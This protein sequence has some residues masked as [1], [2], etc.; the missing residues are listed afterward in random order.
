MLKVCQSIR[1]GIL[2][3]VMGQRYGF[4]KELAKKIGL[5]DFAK[6]GAS[7]IRILCVICKV[8]AMCGVN[9]IYHTMQPT[10][11]NKAIALKAP[12]I[13]FMSLGYAILR[14][15]REWMKFNTAYK[16]HATYLVNVGLMRQIAKRAWH[17]CSNIE[18]NGMT[19]KVVGKNKPRHDIHSEAADAFRQF[20]Q[21]Y[22]FDS[23]LN[24]INR[25][26]YRGKWFNPVCAEQQPCIDLTH[27]HFRRVVGE[28][29]VFGTWLKIGKDSSLVLLLRHNECLRVSQ[30]LFLCHRQKYS[31]MAFADPKVVANQ[32]RQFAIGMNKDSLAQVIALTDLINDC[33]S[34][35]IS[36]PPDP[37]ER[38]GRG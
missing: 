28:F 3:Q 37:R 22:K 36:M 32:V 18:R 29:A 19:A 9:I 21:G 12:K 31:Q 30:P 13:C 10:N 23:K 6:H 5:Y 8:S 34:D 17:I 25:G 38:L 7:L 14:L 4:I 16:Q 24:K 11:D 2:A 26:R 35:L 1:F 15:C 20:A 33:L 27:C